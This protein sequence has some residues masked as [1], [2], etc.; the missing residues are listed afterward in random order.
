MLL[1]LFLGSY[2]TVWLS[3]SFGWA[4]K[5]K[6]EP[7]PQWNGTFSLISLLFRVILS[8]KVGLT[9]W[10]QSILSNMSF[11]KSRELQPVYGCFLLLLFCF[12][13]CLKIFHHEFAFLFLR[14]VFFK[15]FFFLADKKFKIVAWMQKINWGDIWV[16]RSFF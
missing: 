14:E 1:L 2:C 12:F 5:A 16:C 6:C 7:R 11:E 10:F 8:G 4:L 3:S 15:L 9:G 13:Y